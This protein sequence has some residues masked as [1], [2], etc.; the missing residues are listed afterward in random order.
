M[1]VLNFQECVGSTSSM[2]SASKLAF[3]NSKLRFTSFFESFRCSAQDLKWISILLFTWASSTVCL[4]ISVLFFLLPFLFFCQQLLSYLGSFSVM[5]LYSHAIAYSGS[6]SSGINLL[7]TNL[8][9]QG[10]RA[11]IQILAVAFFF[12]FSLFYD[13]FF[14]LNPGSSGSLRTHVYSVCYA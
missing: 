2:Q 7:I 4:W 6:F 10:V 14:R 1:K 12:N 9:L 13:R 11:Q 3:Y 5:P 8:C